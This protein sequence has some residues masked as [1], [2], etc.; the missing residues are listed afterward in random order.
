VEKM[1]GVVG[2]LILVLLLVF[3]EGVGVVVVNLCGEW[4]VV[5][6]F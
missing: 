6:W 2:E 4:M 3:F 1:W 5:L